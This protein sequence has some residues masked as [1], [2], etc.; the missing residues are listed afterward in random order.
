[1][2]PSLPSLDTLVHPDLHEY[3]TDR[4]PFVAGPVDDDQV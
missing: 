1:M 3:V 4:Y 2:T